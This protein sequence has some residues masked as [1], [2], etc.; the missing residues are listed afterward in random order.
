VIVGIIPARFGSEEIECKVL[1]LIGKKPMIQHVY[2]ACRRSN[3]LEDIVVAADDT[4]IL[5]VVKSFGG[6]GMLISKSHICGTERVAEASCSL[7]ISPSIV[8][9]VQADE[10][11]IDPE[12]IDEALH[13][14]QEN[15][16][17]MSTL[18]YPIKDK[19]SFK[20]PFVVK[21]VTDL[22]GYAMYFSRSPIPYPR[23]ERYGAWRHI[24]VYCYRYS[25]LQKIA[26]LKPSLLELTESLE[27]LRV[28]D[29]G[30]KIKV[31]ASSKPYPGIC[32]NTPQ[33]LMLA[34][35]YY[36]ENF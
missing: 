26:S 7:P 11:F 16:E 4:R 25:F 15:E 27:Q 32:A 1:A 24:G 13:P 5:D 9:N 28:L 21:V 23:W 2:E 18:S 22:S 12:M 34:R 30:F 8:V 19:E 17:V 31:V 6:K 33:D 36:T 10:P 14:L 3:V 20:N 29:Y 35:R